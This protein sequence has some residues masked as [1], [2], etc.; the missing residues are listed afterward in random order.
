MMLNNSFISLKIEKIYIRIT[1][2][3]E[4]NMLFSFLLPKYWF[5]QNIKSKC[6]FIDNF[7]MAQFHLIIMP[8]CIKSYCHTN[9]MVSIDVIEKSKNVNRKNLLHKK[10]YIIIQYVAKNRIKWMKLLMVFAR[11]INVYHNDSR[12]F[13]LCFVH[14]HKDRIIS[15]KK[16]SRVRQ[17]DWMN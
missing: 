15:F 3:I 17:V 5:L 14:F 16:V 7:A 10:I 1:T 11:Y 12:K 2:I 9:I 6:W 13:Y 8:Y 4:L